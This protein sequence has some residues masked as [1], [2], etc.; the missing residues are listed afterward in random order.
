MFLRSLNAAMLGCALGMASL[1]ALALGLGRLP[2]AVPLGQALDLQLPLR[3]DTG[4]ALSAACVQAEVRLGAQRLPEALLDV[5]LEPRGA[6]GEVL[7][8]LRSPRVVDEPLVAVELTL[9]CTGEVSRQFTVFADPAAGAASAGGR[10]VGVPPQA[11]SQASR[12][13]AVLAA[14]PQAATAAPGAEV[15][16]RRAKAARPHSDIAAPASSV[17]PQLADASPIPASTALATA[18][19][20]GTGDVE[21]VAGAVAVAELQ[22]QAMA[23][24]LQAAREEAAVQHG[25]IEQLRQRLGRSENQVVTPST[26]AAAV[27]ALALL[28]LGLAWRLRT[29][30]RERRG[31]VAS[32]VL[33]E[34]PNEVDA[35]RPAA[36]L[37][38]AAAAASPIDD[39]IDL[40]QQV[41]FFEVLGDEQALAERLLSQLRANGDGAGPLPYLQLLEVLRSRG[42]HDGCER[43]RVRYGSRFDTDTAAAQAD[44]RSARDLQ[45]CPEVLARLQ[46][47]WAQPL[48]AMA[49]LQRLLLAAPGEPL[50]QLP[51]CR[52]ALLLYLLAREREQRPDHAAEVGAVDL[53]L[54]LA[55][56]DEITPSIFDSLGPA[57]A[58]APA[59]PRLPRL[60]T[61]AAPAT[62]G[63]AARAR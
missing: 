51:A 8:R 13:A 44:G 41:E 22:V 56:H 36:P 38:Q 30:Q 15:A 57:E 32:S 17:A 37:A 33:A 52:D 47:A 40:V 46:R 3:L 28:V 59:P 12:S 6:T 39:L 58:G 24:A 31:S 60:H 16:G 23:A 7:L 29:L 21:P 43:L 55:Q 18:P 63:A 5:S 54:P 10:A 48:V 42:D 34:L 26:L 19:A 61:A 50:L 2:Q 4:Q 35:P 25:V 62:A 27:A 9:G 14:S 11:R 1:P 20:P 53:L 45:D 49:E